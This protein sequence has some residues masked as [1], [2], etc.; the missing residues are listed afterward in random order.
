[1]KNIKHI[2]FDTDG[3]LVH[4]EPWS[5]RYAREA[6]VT[7]DMQVFFRGIFQ[8]CLLGKEDLKQVLGPYLEQW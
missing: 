2:L 6:G 8:D 7:A 3:V 1:M 4:A 5:I